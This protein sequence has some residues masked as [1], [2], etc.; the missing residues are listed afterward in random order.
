MSDT[1]RYQH[2]CD[3]C[4]YLGNYEKCDLYVCVGKA[5]NEIDCTVIARYGDQGDY[6]SGIC[7]RDHIKPLGVAFDRAVK[8]GL[9]DP[10][11]FK[12]VFKC[13]KC[14]VLSYE[15]TNCICNLCNG[16]VLRKK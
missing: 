11:N 9:L 2:D 14:G 13:T 10:K 3:H 1:P 12:P 16:L 5:Q 7:F 8:L 6:T 4:V 15:S